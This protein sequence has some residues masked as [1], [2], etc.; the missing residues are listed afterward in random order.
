ME[1][2]YN[3]ERA[4]NT[5]ACAISSGKVDLVRFFL[6]KGAKPTG[7]YLQSEDTYLG[8]AARLPEP[9]MLKLLIEHGAEL[10][11][12]QALRQAVQRGQVHNAKFLIDQGVDVNEAYTR[13]CYAE[14][15][16]QIWGPSF[17]CAVMGTPLERHQRQASK[18]EM[19]RFLLSHGAN[20]EALDGAGRTPCQLAVEKGEHGVVDVFKEHGVE[21]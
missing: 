5:T 17:H 4:C 1:P 2:D 16:H 10:E 15:K 11:G 20:V 19:V 6:S 14:S 3:L 8:A 9:D 7:R 13:Y 12:S 21:R 18:A